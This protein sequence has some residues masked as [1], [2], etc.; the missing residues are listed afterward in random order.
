MHGAQ[1]VSQHVVGLDLQVVGLQ[2]DGHVA[3]AQVV[4]GA[5]EVEG[6]AVFVVVIVRGAGGD[7]QHGLRRGDHADE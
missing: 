5:H 4:G 7:L 3:V 6:A 2:F 1:H